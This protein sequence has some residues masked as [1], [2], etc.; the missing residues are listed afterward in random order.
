MLSKLRNAIKKSLSN[1]SKLS[2]GV[3]MDEEPKSE[4]SGT[5][6]ES[7]SEPKMESNSAPASVRGLYGRGA[8]IGSLWNQ[9]RVQVEAQDGFRQ[10]P[11]SVSLQRPT[12]AR[13]STI[14]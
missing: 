5:K 7:K 9:V 2:G 1:L 13:P 6:S 8:Q 11:A 10:R 14:F 4:V 3:Y 12:R